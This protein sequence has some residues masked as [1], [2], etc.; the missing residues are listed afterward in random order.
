MN[1]WKLLELGRHL[2][3]YPRMEISESQIKS[4]A[5]S[6]MRSQ[7][8]SLSSRSSSQT[9]E[10]VM[11][12]LA[13]QS[14][15]P[16]FE[17]Q[18]QSSSGGQTI[19]SVVPTA[20]PKAREVVVVKEEGGYR[21]DIVGTYARWNHLQG[22]SAD[23]ALYTATGWI[24]PTLA[25][26]SAFVGE[27]TLAPCQSNLKQ[28]GLGIAM[29]TQDYDEKLPP[30]RRWHDV[31]MPYIKSEQVFTC[32]AIARKSDGYAYNSKMSQVSLGYIDAPAQTVQTY[33]TSNLNRNVFAPFTGRAYRHTRKG[34]A[35][36]NI[37]FADG[38][39][40]W[41]KQGTD[42]PPFPLTQEPVP[43]NE[44]SQ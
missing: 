19:V 14:V 12:L 30:A 24:S 5:G 32:P 15:A 31:V 41:F 26:Q 13:T 3:D 1:F 39:V 9:S 25:T 18:I 34:K 6:V 28:I 33:E 35:G 16:T 21:V 44:Y 40:K 2:R 23:K 22:L 29:Y 20:H 43:E 42:T 10:K 7:Y 17:G 27:T 36:I 37:A 8:E 38:H 11:V 4:L